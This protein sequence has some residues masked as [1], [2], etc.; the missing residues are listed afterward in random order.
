MKA[1]STLNDFFKEHKLNY[2]IG[3]IWLI[4]IDGVQIVVPQ[5]LRKV[6]NLLQY[7]QLTS[8]ELIKYI[9]L[10]LLTGLAIA[11]G[12][13]FWRVYIFGTSRKLEYHLRD[14]L[15]NHLLT[16]S[17]NYFNIH[18]TGDLMAHATNDIN[19]V[20]ASLGQGIVM[21]VDA[22][23]LTIMSIIMMA[24]TT[25]IKL[26]TITLLTLPFITI[27][28]GKFGKII[29]KRFRLVQ[30]AFSNLTDI[31][32]ENF[33][34]IRVIKSFVQEESAFKKFTQ[35]NEY[36]LNKNM[37][38][39][40]VSGIFHP[41]VQF[42][43]SLSFLVVIVYGSKLVMLDTISL[44]DFIAFNN[45]LGLLIWPMM[46]VGFVINIIQR[47]IASMER[48]N[49]I[50]NEKPEIVDF[51][52]AIPLAKVKGKIEYKNVYFKYPNS[53]SYALKNINFTVKEGN[54]LAI[55][56]RTGS[57]KTTIVN[58]LL[59]LYDIDKGSILLDN[60]DIRNIQ[61]KSLRENISYVPQ[62]NFL[63]SSTIRDNIGFA[64]D[65]E[66]SEEQIIYASKIAEVYDD[67][68]ELPDGFDTVLGERGVTLSGGQKQRVAIARAIVKDA[69]ILILD[70]S[71]SSVDTQTEERIL[72]NLKNVMSKKTTI[73]IS[74]RISTVK[75]A[76]QIIVLDEGEIIERG[77]HE[78]L[79]EIDG[80][81]KYLHEKQL[82]EEKVYGNAKE[83]QYE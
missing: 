9:I 64:F 34:G 14:M 82:L 75:N 12:R 47:G 42:I 33:S 25:N 60:I 30:E 1:F 3:I 18:T 46:A 71:L 6:T 37:E 73:I 22:I 17:T 8:Q 55:V 10:I 2:I 58:L 79:L 56:G 59:R 36:N 21:L 13:Y 67:I 70:D 53:Q 27:I 61:I 28:V 49:N 76:D 77:N 41:L 11:I 19:A 29:H 78:S 83:G 54:T 38:L 40:K 43:S 68:M 44:G 26:T 74:H 7:G 50:L 24:K 20:R 66:I 51:P 57:G 35:A 65:K 15:F 72:N 16:L 62:D 32:R 80:L 52:N 81:Y 5:I 4:L 23:F 63:F 31:T 48:I 39:V 69:P 45:Y